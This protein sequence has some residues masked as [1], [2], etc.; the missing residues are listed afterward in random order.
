MWKKSASR[1]RTTHPG[2]SKFEKRLLWCICQRS[3]HLKA[4]CLLLVHGRC[5]A[6]ESAALLTTS[7]RCSLSP[8]LTRGCYFCFCYDCFYILLLAP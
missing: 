3:R 7:V 4:R 6:A 1:A 2:F 8:L 5:I